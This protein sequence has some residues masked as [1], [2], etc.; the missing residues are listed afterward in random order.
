[1]AQIADVITQRTY[2]S[3]AS[4]GRY[5][6]TWL[7]DNNDGVIDDGESL[8]FTASSFIGREGYLGVS[9][10]E[11]ANVVNYVRGQESEGSRSRTIDYDGDGDEDI[12]RLGDVVHSTPQLVAAPGGRYDALYQ[13]TTYQTFRAHYLN[14]RHVLYV[15]ANDGMV[16]AFN[17]G[18]WNETSYSYSATGNRGESSHPL[19]SE[20]WAYTPMNLLPHLRWLKEQSYPHVYY[21]D[22]EPL[23]F[24]ANIFDPEDSN[25]PGGWGSVL[26]IGMRLGGGALDVTVDGDDRT[27]RSAYVVLDVT[28]PEQP[29]KLIAEITHPK[30][31]LTTSKP[32]LVKRRVADTDSSGD[33]DWSKDVLKNEWYLV[34]ASGPYGEGESGIRDAIESGN[35]DQNLRVFAYDLSSRSFVAGLDPLVSN[36]PASYAGDMTA[37]DWDSDYQDDVVYFGSV[38]TSSSVLSGRILRLELSQTLSE[39]QISTLLNVGKPVTAAPVTLR[40]NQDY[41]IYSGTGRLLTYSDNSQT[42]QQFFYGLKEPMSNSVLS[43]G[44]L[45]SDNVI[46]TTQVEVLSSGTI[47]EDTADGYSSF[48][49]DNSTVS[50]FDALKSVMQSKSGW[51]IGMNH[52]GQNPAGRN[53]SSASRLFS[54]L[55]FTEYQPSLNSCRAD[56]RSYL[57][58]VHYQTG[59]ATPEDVIDYV[60]YSGEGDDQISVSKI[61]VGIGYAS[62]PVIH[63]G[64]EGRR[65]AVTQGAGGSIDRQVLNYEFSTSGRMS[66]RQIFEIP[67]L[68]Q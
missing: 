45:S 1:M 60:E 61:L 15:G 21:M 51:R 39:S 30:L 33:Y 46:D 11:A 53:V 17:G 50:N 19:G 63:Q 2:E 65:S 35:S 64:E 44:S 10:A 16:H 54:L 43:Y 42:N 36:L 66:W 47:V 49:V 62:A 4:S 22:G 6:F 68:S 67:W 52:D 59:T 48:E 57:N 18:F 28:N 23:V 58:G 14:R 40:D 20:L 3:L 38:D 29:P 27:M 41:W 25:Y 12:W 13:D 31:G 32:V 7:D 9:T 5:I 24:D 55:F 26:V 37:V 8:P 56:G 34:F